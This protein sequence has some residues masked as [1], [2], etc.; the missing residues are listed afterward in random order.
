LGF[1]RERS[2][3]ID[4]IPIVEYARV[5]KEGK[6]ARKREKGSVVDSTVAFIR[7]ILSD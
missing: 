1:E 6:Q 2:S 5:L 3:E 4:F 7:L